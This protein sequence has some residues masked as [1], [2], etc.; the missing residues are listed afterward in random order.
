MKTLAI[1][2]VDEDVNH[3][4]EHVENWRHCQKKLPLDLISKVYQKALKGNCTTEILTADSGK[5]WQY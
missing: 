4:N 1:D 5:K 2:W 3:L